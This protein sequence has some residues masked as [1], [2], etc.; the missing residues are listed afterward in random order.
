MKTVS[1]FVFFV[2]V[3]SAL[4]AIAELQWCDGK[5]QIELSGSIGIDSG[6]VDRSGDYMLRAMVDY[7][8]PFADHVTLGLRALPLFVYEQ[9]EDTVWGGGLGLGLRCYSVANEY[10]G[11]FVEAAAYA[12]GHKNH[13][14][15]NSANI[16]F[17]TGFGVGY[18]CKENWSGV[19]RWEHI[20]NA[21]ISKH[22]SG[23]NLFSLGV[24]YAF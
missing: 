3:L 8:V 6:K 2:C 14:E 4:P 17:L 7:E 19:L 9:D 12:L 16:N 20:S 5:W 23:V 15:G 1:F 22:N 18:K 11:W 13:F 21:N 24:G 10:R